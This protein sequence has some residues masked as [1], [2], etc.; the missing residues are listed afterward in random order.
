MKSLEEQ[1]ETVQNAIEAIELYGQSYTKDSDG[2]TITMTK[3]NLSALY[4]RESNLLL[5]L[6]RRQN[7]MISYGVNN[8]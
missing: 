2:N 1:I 7:G 8:S 6:H 3:A 4:K 5:R